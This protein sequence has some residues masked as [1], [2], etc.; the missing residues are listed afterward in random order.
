MG[1]WA[2]RKWR[3]AY[4]AE[5]TGAPFGFVYSPVPPANPGTPYV[6][7]WDYVVAPEATWPNWTCECGTH[8]DGHE[9]A[10]VYCGNV[11]DDIDQCG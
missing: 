7:A 11:R 2:A 8:N 3:I 1:S 5:D 9:G 10:C 6:D 4:E